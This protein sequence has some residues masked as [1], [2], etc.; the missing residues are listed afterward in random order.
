M[1]RTPEISFDEKRGK[2]YIKIGK[3]TLYDLG[4]REWIQFDDEKEAKDFR[5]GFVFGLQLAAT[6]MRDSLTGVTNHV[7]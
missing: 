3:E 2:Y 5:R 1:Y 6:M 7:D 4:T